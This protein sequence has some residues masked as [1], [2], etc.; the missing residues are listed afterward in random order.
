M[1]PVNAT[2]IAKKG[3]TLQDASAS[4]TTGLCP[5]EQVIE[6]GSAVHCVSAYEGDVGT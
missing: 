3:S 2:P 4:A 1:D 5:A 6:K